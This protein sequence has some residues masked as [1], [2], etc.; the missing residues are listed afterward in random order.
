[1]SLLHQGLGALDPDFHRGDESG[2]G[3]IML[4]KNAV[5]PTEVGIQWREVF[6]A[7]TP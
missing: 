3:C 7:K 6:R 1:M 5:I 4:S 2:W